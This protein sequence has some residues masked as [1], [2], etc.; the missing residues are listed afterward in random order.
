MH[1]KTSVIGLMALTASAV[2]AASGSTSTDVAA[3]SATSSPEMSIWDILHDAHMEEYLNAQ[4]T[5]IKAR[6]ANA[7]ALN[8]WDVLNAAAQHIDLDP[9]KHGRRIRPGRLSGPIIPPCSWGMTLG[10]ACYY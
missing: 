6:D 4:A 2:V 1:F 7:E 9:V 10:Q 8:A 5:G 3:A